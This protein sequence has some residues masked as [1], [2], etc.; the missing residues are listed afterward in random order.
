MKEN[1]I[2]EIVEDDMA[3][4]LNIGGRQ[5]INLDSEKLRHIKHLLVKDLHI[6][7]GE[8]AEKLG[9]SYRTLDRKLG[10]LGINLVEYQKI[11]LVMKSLVL[12]KNHDKVGEVAKKLGFCDAVYFSK[13]FS[14]IIGISPKQYELSDWHKKEE[15]LDKYFSLLK[16]YDFVN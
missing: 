11:N 3:R 8:I 6:T 15:I 2:N 12:L 13:W 1:T 14:G 5:K 16:I 7:K 10:D 4:N 9:Y